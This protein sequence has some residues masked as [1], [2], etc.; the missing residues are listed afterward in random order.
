ML[1]AIEPNTQALTWT[2]SVTTALVFYS[3]EEVADV[4][5]LFS[6]LYGCYVGKA[7]MGDQDVG[8]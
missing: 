8:K 4:I 7:F 1:A 3:A 5:G 6:S 2:K